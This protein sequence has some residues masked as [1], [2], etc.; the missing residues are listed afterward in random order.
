M[1]S[2]SSSDVSWTAQCSDE[3]IKHGYTIMRDMLN[4]IHN[5][6]KIPEFRM[7]YEDTFMIPPLYFYLILNPTSYI[8]ANSEDCSKITDVHLKIIEKDLFWMANPFNHSELDTRIFFQDSKNTTDVDFE[9]CAYIVQ[10]FVTALTLWIREYRIYSTLHN[11]TNI[12]YAYSADEYKNNCVALYNIL[13]DCLIYEEICLELIQAGNIDGMDEYSINGK[14]PIMSSLI[15]NHTTLNVTDDLTDVSQDMFLAMKDSHCFIREESFHALHKVRHDIMTALTEFLETPAYGSDSLIEDYG[16]LMSH[17]KDMDKKTLEY[18]KLMATF[19]KMKPTVLKAVKFN[20]KSD[21]KYYT[22]VEEEE[23][24]QSVILHGKNIGEYSKVE[25]ESKLDTAVSGASGTVGFVKITFDDTIVSE[26]ALKLVYP[27]E[28]FRKIILSRVKDDVIYTPIDQIELTLANSLFCIHPT[29][30]IGYFDDQIIPMNVFYSLFLRDPRDHLVLNLMEN[31]IYDDEK[32]N[33]DTSLRIL[34]KD[35]EPNEFIRDKIF[36]VTNLLENYFNIILNSSDMFSELTSEIICT[37]RNDAHHQNRLSLMMLDKANYNQVTSGEYFEHLP[38]QGLD[39]AS[40]K[41]FRVFSAC[42][43]GAL[44]DI[45][46][47]MPFFRHNDMHADNVLLSKSPY[48]ESVSFEFDN[49]Q[50]V[51]TIDP[52]SA[53]PKM[54]DFSYVTG[55]VKHG[56]TQVRV[57]EWLTLF[58][59]I[60]IEIT[61]LGSNEFYLHVYGENKQLLFFAHF[62]RITKSR[63][64]FFGSLYMKQTIY[65]ESYPNIHIT[66][67]KENMLPLHFDRFLDLFTEKP[68]G[69]HYSRPELYFNELCKLYVGVNLQGC[70]DKEGAPNFSHFSAYFHDIAMFMISQVR[71]LLSKCRTITESKDRSNTVKEKFTQSFIVLMVLFHDLLFMFGNCLL[72]LI[73]IFAEIEKQKGDESSEDVF[74]AILYKDW[75]T[76]LWIPE[77]ENNKLK[78]AFGVDKKFNGGKFFMNVNTLIKQ[79]WQD[80][81]VN[82]SEIYIFLENDKTVDMQSKRRKCQALYENNNL[83]ALFLFL[84]NEDTFIDTL[85]SNLPNINI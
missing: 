25:I 67:D 3:L 40:L 50:L 21:E 32:I 58:R 28:K 46:K 62:Q 56:T 79:C 41:S 60:E 55:F 63:D 6:W 69:G 8:Y 30:V 57:M 44:M 83:S 23:N 59:P 78:I 65:D 27:D 24:I 35:S 38:D 47:E 29:F 54:H 48:K 81:V 10:I 14:I 39:V 26:V 73:P 34:K 51:V 9:H 17:D 13:S 52:K 4:V 61:E 45:Q 85:V 22:L 80:R 84:L 74:N 70:Y 33:L 7:E 43:H 53:I 5:E 68:D 16:L 76:S 42:L 36:S 64:K 71:I 49:K 37:L 2:S 20:G 75:S 12:L 31:A 77:A 19:Q 72:I 15:K 82:V 11:E 1:T 18:L 66:F